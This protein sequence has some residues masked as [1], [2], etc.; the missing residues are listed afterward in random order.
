LP[1]PTEIIDQRY[2]DR[3]ADA[4]VNLTRGCAAVCWAIEKAG[5]GGIV[6]LVGFDNLKAGTCLPVEQAFPAAYLDHYDRAYPGWRK[7]WYPARGGARCGS[8]D[9]AAERGLIEGLAAERGVT[10]A[11]AEDIW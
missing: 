10:V 4:A 11:F 5:A 3:I 8:H 9:I 2:R 7:S 1:A 6:T